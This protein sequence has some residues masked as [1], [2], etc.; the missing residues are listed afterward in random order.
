M[1]SFDDASSR[2]LLIG[3]GDT[4]S[5]LNQIMAGRRLKKGADG[6]KRLAGTLAPPKSANKNRKT[7]FLQSIPISQN[8]NPETTFKIRQTRF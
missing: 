3:D 1:R 6:L 7:F 2:R 5:L 8:R 4:P